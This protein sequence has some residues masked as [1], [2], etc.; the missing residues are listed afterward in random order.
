VRFSWDPPKARANLAEHGVSFAEAVTVLDDD[1]A[2]TREDPDSD[3]NWARRS[4][5]GRR[6]VSSE[7]ARRE[8]SSSSRPGSR[9]TMRCDICAADRAQLRHVTRSFGRG[10]RLVVIENIPYI[11]CGR[12]GERYLTAATM[13]EIERLKQL[14]ADRVRR[15]P[16]PVVSFGDA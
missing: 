9:T 3:E 5:A 11:V 4:A 13:R 10:D 14:K 2:L 6:G 7:S 15:K 8:R 1:Q 16:V 12:C